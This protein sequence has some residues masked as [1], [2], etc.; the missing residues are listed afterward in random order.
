MKL[1]AKYCRAVY[2]AGYQ[3]ICPMMMHSLFLR[4]AIPQEHKD[5]LDMSKDY[6][7]RSALLVVCGNAVDET[8]KN[9]IALAARFHKPATTLDG[10]LTV[11][12]QGRRCQNGSGCTCL[13]KATRKPLRMHGAGTSAF[14]PMRKWFKGTYGMITKT[15][16]GKGGIRMKSLLRRLVVPP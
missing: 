12:G 1:A 9:D 11:K 15:K 7:Y 8:M 14:F 13:K 5:G 16:F 2:D 6:L 3:P 4:E 10:I